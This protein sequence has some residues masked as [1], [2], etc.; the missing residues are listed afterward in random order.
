[1]E[2]QLTNDDEITLPAWIG[3][4]DLTLAEIGAIA[5]LSCLSAYGDDAKLAER[6]NS[7]AMKEAM[8]GLKDKGVIRLEI[9]DGSVGIKLDLDVIR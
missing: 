1:M 4:T 9:E 5:S 7:A 2:L 8:Q 3:T 6:I